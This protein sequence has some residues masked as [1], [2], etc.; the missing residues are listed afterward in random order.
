MMWEQITGEGGAVPTGG[1]RRHV[2]CVG[3]VI[4]SVERQPARLPRPC[5]LLQEGGRLFPE[6]SGRAP[7]GKGEVPP[8]VLLRCVTHTHSNR[9]RRRFIRDLSGY[10]VP[11]RRRFIRDLPGYEIILESFFYNHQQS[12]NPSGSRAWDV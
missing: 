4:K 2:D 5:P 1:L 12:S 7:E 6:G 10:E 8:L 11:G 9:G 3:G